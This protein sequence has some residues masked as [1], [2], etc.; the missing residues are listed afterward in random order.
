M[1]H[2]LIPFSSSADWN[3]TTGIALPSG[4]ITHKGSRNAPGSNRSLCPDP[5][6]EEPGFLAHPCTGGKSEL[7][8]KKEKKMWLSNYGHSLFQELFFFC[9]IKNVGDVP[10]TG[11]IYVETVVDR[12]SG[13]AFAKVYSAKKRD[14]RRRYSR[15]PC[16]A[17]F[18]A[19]RSRNRIN[20]YSKNER[21]LRLASRASL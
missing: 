15:E 11:C 14:E 19:S 17:L 4:H 9:T 16:R 8:E 18:R 3:C 1:L 2:E 21:I 13:I 7:M 5:F 10:G 6:T 20:S 12:D